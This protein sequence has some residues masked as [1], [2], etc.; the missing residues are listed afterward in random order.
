MGGGPQL[1]L[2]SEDSCQLPSPRV[3]I[4]LEAQSVK[5]IEV[6]YSALVRH[7]YCDKIRFRS[8]ID[9]P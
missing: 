8:Q 2:D 4:I 7:T 6:H 9:L 3:A 5:A 1:E